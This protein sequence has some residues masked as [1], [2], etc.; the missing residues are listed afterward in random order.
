MP[1]LGLLLAPTVNFLV[2]GHATQQ[3]GRSAQIA[4]SRVLSEET[5]IQVSCSCSTAGTLCRLER[6][7]A[8]LTA[9]PQIAPSFPMVSGGSSFLLASPWRIT[10]AKPRSGGN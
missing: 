2:H 3:A 9:A 4:L 6:R 10:K 7:V 8:G 5:T 1:A